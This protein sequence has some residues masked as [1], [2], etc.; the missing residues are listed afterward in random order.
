M[1]AKISALTALAGQNVDGA[2]DVLPIVDTSATQTKKITVAEFNL[3]P[4]AQRRYG[5]G[6]AAAPAVALAGSGNYNDGLYWVGGGTVGLA[7]NGL[8]IWNFDGAQ[9]Y[10]PADGGANVGAT[11][12]RIGTVYTKRAVTGQGANVAAA[13]D[14]VLGSD[15]NGF[16][17]TGATQ[18]NLIDR[19]NWLAGAE[20]SLLF[21]STPTVKHGQATSG[22][23]TQI[24]LAGA[25][26]FVA[27]ANDVLTLVL[28]ADNIWRE[29]CRTVI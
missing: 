15:G 3:F 5:N 25:V 18:I 16:N 6:T 10:P 21:A 12:L 20:I 28:W 11:N 17:I 19:S 26:D 9:L 2:L 8:N 7:A 14:L 1:S 22:N 29:K 23:N 24:L 27:T 4:A 13:N